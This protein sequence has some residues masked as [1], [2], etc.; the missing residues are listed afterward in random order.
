MPC[1]SEENL[2][3]K[4]WICKVCR[5]LESRN[6]V[7]EWKVGGGRQRNALAFGLSEN[8]ASSVHM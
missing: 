2:G 4:D 8:T 3:P 6:C 5:K 1:W 7:R